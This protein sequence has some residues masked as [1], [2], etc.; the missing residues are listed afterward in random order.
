MVQTMKHIGIALLAITA[1]AVLYTVTVLYLRPWFLTPLVWIFGALFA[2]VATRRQ[3]RL[4]RPQA[5]GIALV[6]LAYLGITWLAWGSLVGQST[7]RMFSMVWENR[8]AANQY[9][10]AEVRLEYVEFPGH[11]EG[12]YSDEL[13][14]YLSDGQEN[15]VK[16]TIVLRQN[17]GKCVSGFY[18]KQ[19]GDLTSWESKSGYTE[20]LTIDGD[21]PFQSPRWC[22]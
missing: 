16:V 1:I 18:L 6:V 14:H 2:V 7:D 12:V 13:L 20:N 11:Y 19:I 9:E 21:S 10:E 22:P 15:P 3:W 8:G 5:V 4:T 17:L